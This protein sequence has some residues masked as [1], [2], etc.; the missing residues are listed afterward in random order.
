MFAGVLVVRSVDQINSTQRITDD[1]IQ[2]NLDHSLLLVLKEVQF[3]SDPN[4]VPATVRALID[5]VS[6]V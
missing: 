3:I 2:V 1:F 6:I 4:S 5:Q